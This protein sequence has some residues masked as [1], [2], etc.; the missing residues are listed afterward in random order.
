M[1]TFI[2]TIQD[3]ENILPQLSGEFTGKTQVAAERKARKHYASELDTTV[4]DI[5]VI[6]TIEVI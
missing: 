4:E 1:K 2:I 5:Q 6:G 3:S